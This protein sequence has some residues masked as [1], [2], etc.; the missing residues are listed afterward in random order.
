[1]NRILIGV[2]ITPVLLFAACSVFRPAE[3][4]REQSGRTVYRVPGGSAAELPSPTPAPQNIPGESRRAR[5]S[6]DN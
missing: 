3:E 5:S 6:S 1:V 2:A 4:Y